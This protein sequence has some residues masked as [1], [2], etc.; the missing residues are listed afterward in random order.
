L[1]RF[2]S[3]HVGDQFTGNVESDEDRPH[4]E[5]VISLNG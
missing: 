3:G 1:N 4:V 2:G 5:A